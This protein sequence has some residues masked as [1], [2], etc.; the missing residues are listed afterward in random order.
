MSSQ[1]FNQALL[2]KVFPTAVERIGYPVRVECQ[3][4]SWKELDIGDQ[5][6]PLREESQDSLSG[7]EPLKRVIAPKKQ[8]RIVPTIHVA[9]APVFIIV[10]GKEERCIGA[11]GR[12]FIK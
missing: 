8:R 5:A 3:C 6:V 10:C 12:I 9:Q 7:I 11:V 4:V 2:S 1:C